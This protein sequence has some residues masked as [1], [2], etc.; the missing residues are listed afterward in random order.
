MRVP[1]LQHPG[2][3]WELRMEPGVH[4]GGA[5]DSPDNNVWQPSLHMYNAATNPEESLESGTMWVY[6]DGS[7][8]QSR[9]GF[10]DVSC[11]F[12]GLVN[13]PYDELSCPFDYGAWN[14][15][16]NVI[17][18]SFYENGGILVD[19]AQET[20]GTSYQEY[21]IVRGETKKY[22][23]KYACCP[24]PFTNLVF[25]LFFK[26][27]QS[28]YFLAIELP[29]FLLTA[30]SMVVFWLDATNCGERLGFGVTMLL[31]IEVMKIVVSELLPICGETLWIEILL[32]VNELWCAICI[33]VSCTAIYQAYKGLGTTEEHRSDRVDYWARRFVPST[34]AIAIGI[35]YSITL[36]DGYMGSLD[37]MFQGLGKVNASGKLA[38]V[39]CVLVVIVGTYVL[40]KRSNCAE[41]MKFLK[42]QPI[43]A[44]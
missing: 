3:V 26:R 19:A 43:H 42:K 31:A 34:Y 5:A 8:F 30:V 7:V 37:P 12:T 44:K 41:R 38:I 29:G 32:F 35:V 25:R 13:F 22:T 4:T 20:A 27:P 21:V 17:N 40:A 28:Y 24:E 33:L 23:F 14:Y 9:P 2:G 10:L 39:P 15:G 16:D 1:S 36:D 6:S 18:M 11:R